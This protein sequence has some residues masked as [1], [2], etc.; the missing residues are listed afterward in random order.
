MQSIHRSLPAR[1]S[2]LCTAVMS[3]CAAWHDPVLADTPPAEA[4][5][6]ASAN[7]VSSLDA[8]IVTAQRRREPAREVPLSAD[9][10]KGEAMER[11]G[12]QSLGDV[13]ALLPGVNFSQSGTGTGQ[14]QISMR[15]ITTG[16]QVGA[17]VGMYVDDVPFGSSSAYAGGGSSS[18]D[19]G[20]FDLAAVE[21]LRGPQGTLYG[22]SAMGGLIKYIAAEPESSYFGGQATAEISSIKGGRPGHVLRGMVNAPVKDGVAA[23]RATVYQR[24]DGGFVRDLNHGGRVVDGSQTDGARVALLLTPSKTLTVRLTAITQRQERDGSSLED[25]NLATGQP[26]DRRQTKRLFVDE[27]VQ[28]RSDLVSAAVKADLTWATLDA[29]TGWQRS[30]NN[31]RADPSALYVPFLAQVGIVNPGYAMDYSFRNR[32]LTQELRL[33]SPRSRQFEWLAGAFY[34]EER[35][36]KTQHLDPLD[37][38]GRPVPPL[39]LDAVFPSRFREAAVFG[40]GT[41]YLTTNADLTMGVRHSQNHQ[42]LDQTFS[43][44]MA[45]APLPAASSS[46]NVTTWLLTGRWRVSPDHAVY[47]RAASGYRP[48]GP[49]PVIN[50]PVTGQPLNLPSF[51]S[52]KLWSYEL[53]WKGS[54]IPNRLSTDLALYQID[55]KDI[56]VFTSS[57]GFSGIGNAGRA[58]S[59]GMEWTV[60]AAPRDDLRV[61]GALSLIDATLM[62]DSPDLGGRAGERL[63]DTARWSAALQADQE[64]QLFGRRAYLGATLRHTGDRFTSF[65]AAKAGPQYRLP[66]FTTVD[67]RGGIEFGRANLGFFVRNLGN[68]RGQLSAD[69]GL[70][71][72]G[73]PARVNLIAP[74]TIGLQLTFDFS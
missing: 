69:T 24:K 21:V 60:R 64:F 17:T 23:L 65:D 51:K 18:L 70:S 26:V 39:L 20:L 62:E 36:T 31:G 27:P 68:Q 56:Q 25:V 33:T 61:S 10:L 42:R 34:T 11:G 74:R 4:E 48:G 71:G 5:S 1:L 43:G 54:L 6:R 28:G 59:R 66:A 73:G 44:V 8:V 32:K 47:A 40:T 22:A 63:P 14:S 67:L 46:E 58:R 35:G 45:P 13:A 16:A 55:W 12:Y 15:G 2:F 41:Y 7:K 9:V 49:L 3:A 57:A 53:G 30:V 19:L 52:D 50:S 29:I 37:A 38:Q 72:A